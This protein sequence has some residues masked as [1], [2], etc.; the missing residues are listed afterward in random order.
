MFTDLVQQLQVR[1]L[2]KGSCLIVI[3]PPVHLLHSVIAKKWAAAV[4]LVTDEMARSVGPLRQELRLEQEQMR[5]VQISRTTASHRNSE[6]DVIITSP[7]ERPGNLQDIMTAY[8][9]TSMCDGDIRALLNDMPS[10]SLVVTYTIN[11]TQ[12]ETPAEVRSD[13]NSYAFA[14]L[15]KFK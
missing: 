13:R 12:T 10:G 5:R 7:G 4:R 8:I 14:G 9:C 15:S 1:N 11:G 6:N 2:T 3:E